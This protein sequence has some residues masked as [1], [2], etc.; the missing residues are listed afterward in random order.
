MFDLHTH[1]VFSFDGAD[2]ATPDAMCQS[3]I[4]H[5]ITCLAITDHCDA[6][7]EVGGIYRI[8]DRAAAY[9]AVSE[10]KERYRGRLRVLYGIELGEATQAPEYAKK[11]LAD[12]RFDF[13]L[14]SMHNLLGVPDF[15][16][17]NFSRAD[18]PDALLEEL[19]SRY[20]TELTELCDFDGIHAL[21]H[22]TYPLRYFAEGGK[23]INLSRFEEQFRVLFEKM[24]GRG[25]ALEIN[26][27]G[28]DKPLADTMP[29]VTLLRIYR[30]CG[31]KLVTVGSDA[32]CPS[33]VG[34]GIREA[35]RML[36]ENGFDRV[37]VFSEGKP[38][39]LP[40]L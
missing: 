21:A 6:G 4:A 18:F 22:L 7:G 32:H 23:Q 40:T 11:L 30:E 28:L 25:I 26:T 14:G 19:F 12:Y 31:G 2:N 8:Y 5:G 35:H 3:A 27:S 33:R 1:T 20:L 34:F 24:I 10:V 17:L 39:L 16:Y 38:E 13:V 9:R 36:S 37:A 29:P 15:Y